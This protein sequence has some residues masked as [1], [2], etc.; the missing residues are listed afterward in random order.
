MKVKTT[1]PLRVALGLAVIVLASA[2]GSSAEPGCDS[3][4]LQR[5]ID[6]YLEALV[7]HDPSKAPF[8]SAVKVTENGQRLGVRDGL[9]KTASANSTY[10][11]YFADPHQG[12]VGFIGAIKENDVP[13]LLAL[14]LKVER[15]VITEAEM[16]VA[17]TQAGGMARPEGFTHPK[18]ILT[19]SVPAADRVPREQMIR[20]ADSYFTGLDTDHSGAKVP[21]DPQCQRRENGTET[22]NSSDPKARPMAKLGCKAQFDTGFSVFVTHIRD[23]RYPI[24]DE[25]RGLVYAEVFFDHA[26]NIES[27]KN[28]VDGTVNQV[29]PA[30]R[31]PLTFQIGELFKIEGGKIRQIEAVLYEAPYGMASGWSE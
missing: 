16:I 22:A 20:I 23:R 24:V 31:R 4:C 19:A 12:Q 26:G 18:P 3:G 30:F 14:R 9:W 29:Q 11:L 6:A 13:A 27:W 10:R 7:A 2:H 15:N 1:G 5:F 8:S 25:E 28:A 17:R 21:F